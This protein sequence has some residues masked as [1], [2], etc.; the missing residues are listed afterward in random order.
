MPCSIS[1]GVDNAD[2]V[3]RAANSVQGYLG[4]SPTMLAVTVSDSEGGSGAR[5]DMM[6]LKRCA[7]QYN[8]HFRT[9][10]PF[11]TTPAWR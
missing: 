4:T 5:L 1:T 9:T 8:H 11:L 7:P 3:T 6:H 2:E 10:T